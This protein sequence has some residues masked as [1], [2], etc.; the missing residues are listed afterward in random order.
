MYTARF[1]SSDLEKQ[2]LT[3]HIRNV[4]TIAKTFAKKVH[5]EGT[6]QLAGYLHDMGKYADG[7][8]NY[9]KSEYERAEHDFD[10]YLKHRC[11]SDFDHGVYGAK[12]IYERFHTG[13]DSQKRAAEVL[14]LAVA[15]HHGR[16]PDC[17]D[18]N[19][20]IPIL[21]RL[22]KIEEKELRQIVERFCSD[23]IGEEDLAKLFQQSCRE[24]EAISAKNQRKTDAKFLWNLLVKSVY[25]MLIDADRLDAMCFEMKEPWENY[26]ERENEIDGTWADYQ[27]RFENYLDGLN[28]NTQENIT[29][30]QKE[31]NRIRQEISEEC[32]EKADKPTGIYRL[33]VPTGGGKTFS[34]MRFA[35]EH[36]RMHKKNRIVYVIPYTTIIEQNADVIRRA[37][38]DTCDLLEH[39]SNVLDDKKPEITESHQR[40]WDSKVEFYELCTQRWDNDIIF[41]TMVQF[42][43][44]FYGKSTQDTRRLHHLMNSTIIFDEVQ[45]V[46]VKCMYLFNSA[47]N[48][49]C[50]QGNSTIVLSTATQ[51]DMST[52]RHPVF[53]DETFGQII[54]KA[55]KEYPLLKRTELKDCIKVRQ[56]TMEE[57]EEFVL[58]KKAKVK[59]LLVVVNKV[60]TAN[61]LYERLCDRT[62][63]KVILLT[64]RFCSA[65][66]R[67]I[68]EKLY[69]SLREQENII[70]VSTA[71]IEAGIDI[72]FEA[73]IRNLTKLDSIIQTAGRVNRNGERKRGYCYVVNLD[74]GSYKN[75]L[76]VEQGAMHS[77]AEIFGGFG[78]EKADSQEA[79][80]EYFQRYFE[81]EEI[82]KR[83]VYPLNNKMQNI[84]KLLSV[85]PDN[86]RGSNSRKETRRWELMI[87]FREAADHFVVIEQDTQTVIVPYKGGI[88]LLEE[89]EKVNVHTS[90]KEKRELLTR[91]KDYT[92][93]LYQYQLKQLEEVG[94]AQRNDYLGVWTLG[95]GYY[96][97]D[98]GVVEQAA[99]EEFML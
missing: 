42:L 23:I 68:L 83:L 80:Q 22:E 64:S 62:D 63:T 73:A 16:L 96:D 61:E 34:S 66:K 26:V 51:M 65:N 47:V 21:K 28:Q 25:S 79:I 13:N 81:D 54:E 43:N 48:F 12:Y 17:E 10:E 60:R 40:Y 19:G 74:E 8:Q 78:E 49:L 37:L 72:S 39:H 99:T 58:E 52:M 38:G 53:V 98:R 44:T 32:L 1:R 82:R 29:E 35:I 46:P 89:L 75:M 76:E 33:N 41:T 69:A 20:R 88:K 92:V 90:M 55:W 31:V 3:E 5:L 56:Y 91:A 85:T 4:A 59:S 87:R 6:M 93:N 36:N 84:Y 15:Y 24:I 94:A 70:C 45:S 95:S 9:I 50:Y 71:V 2:L 30:K 67:V 77:D 57:M 11:F 86:Q 14:A 27:K 7:F 97:E 18:D